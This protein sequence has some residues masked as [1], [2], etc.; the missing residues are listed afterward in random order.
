[1]GEEDVLPLGGD[2]LDEEDDDV[3]D[4]VLRLPVGEYDDE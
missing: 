4:G 1:L 2:C 3:C